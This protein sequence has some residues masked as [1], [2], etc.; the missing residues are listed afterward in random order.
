MMLT[1]LTLFCRGDGLISEQEF[2]S[3]CMQ[4]ENLNN[5]FNLGISTFAGITVGEGHDFKS[6]DLEV[7]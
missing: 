4:K 2:V 5:F 1:F 7:Q 6:L 3:S